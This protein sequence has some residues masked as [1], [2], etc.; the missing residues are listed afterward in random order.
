ML[1]LWWPWGK[2]IRSRV[3]RPKPFAQLHLHL[4]ALFLESRHHLAAPRPAE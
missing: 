2:P 1:V 3:Q 4:I